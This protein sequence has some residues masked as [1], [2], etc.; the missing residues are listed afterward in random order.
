MIIYFFLITLGSVYCYLSRSFN[1]EGFKLKK[2]IKKAKK[3]V[4][5]SVNKEVKSAKKT[6]STANKKLSRSSDKKK[7]GGSKNKDPCAKAKKCN[8]DK[9]NGDI[10]KE[11]KRII[12][13]AKKYTK[14]FGNIFVKMSNG[15]VALFEWIIKSLICLDSLII[16]LFTSNIVKWFMALP[17]Y[18][19]ILVV[20][21]TL[22][23]LFI[24]MIVWLPFLIFYYTIYFA[25]YFFAHNQW[26]KTQAK[27]KRCKINYVKQQWE[28]VLN[29]FPDENNWA[30]LNPAYI[31]LGDQCLKA[32]NDC[33][34]HKAKLRADALAA[35]E[36]NSTNAIDMAK[37][38][39]TT[40]Q[41]KDV[42][43]ESQSNIGI[44]I[45][46]ISIIAMS[47]AIFNLNKN[48]GTSNDGINNN[49][50]ASGTTANTSGIPSETGD[51]TSTTTNK[52]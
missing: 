4:K 1:L 22:I 7:S 24:T 19:K 52:S 49:T 17:L 51:S 9:T 15:L 26:K 10:I 3:S 40:T 14:N 32:E 46:I 43:P 23:L 44:I 35:Q 25:R 39:A 33:E 31:I 29:K 6:V 42:A 38:K 8:K 41:E 37:F 34:K 21:L 50:T 13:R 27:T 28:K 2:K 12:K 11:V 18:W 47:F 16:E 45:L 36:T 30:R 5:K 20:I 48:D